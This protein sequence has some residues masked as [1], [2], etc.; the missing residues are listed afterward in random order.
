MS[1]ARFAW[2]SFIVV[3]RPD[4]GGLANAWRGAAVT[5]R[6]GRD[7]HGRQARRRTS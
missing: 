2:F 1:E 4:G 5:S 7:Q 6:A 3:P